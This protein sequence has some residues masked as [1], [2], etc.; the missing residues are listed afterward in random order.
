MSQE[1]TAKRAASNRPAGAHPGEG[2]RRRRGAPGKIKTRHGVD[3]TLLVVLLLLMVIG[4]IMIYSSSGYTSLTMEKS[5]SSYSFLK[6]QLLAEFLGAFATLLIC[7]F[8]FDVVRIF[9]KKGGRILLLIVATFL[10]LLLKTNYGVNVNG[11]TRWVNLFGVVQ[12]QPA[13]FVKIALIFFMAGVI[14]EHPLVMQKPK[15]KR[16]LTVVVVILVNVM[17]VY[18]IS[19]NLS[20]AIIVGAIGF[21]MMFFVIRSWWIYVTLGGA[22]GA[23]VVMV[24][25][26]VNKMAAENRV[27]EMAYQLK[28]VLV[29]QHP[30]SYLKSG[31]Y[32]TVQAL[33]AI[34]SG[35][36]AG[37][38][39][40]NGV[41]K[42][43]VIPEVYNDMIFSEVCEEMG[44]I[45]A[46]LILFLFAILLFRVLYIANNSGT[47]FERMFCLGVFVH[48]AL[49]VILNI[50][51]VTNTMPNTGVSLPFFSYGGTSAAFLT[52]EMGI[53]LA[54]SR[55]IEVKE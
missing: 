38:G 10:M 23:V 22:L 33:Y 7:V 37:K 3:I 54:I 8:P 19:S 11:A 53:V 24:Q 13:E 18:K 46:M 12:F 29:W 52:V 27:D 28:R 30:E 1:Q 47:L 21:G 41:Q 32:Q 6:K 35:G 16:F 44:L 51:V 20:S 5:T 25:K 34:G 9:G 17:L 4:L 36:F 55:R 14:D 49:Q 50:M 26:Y 15:S 48:I 45:G 42:I 2:K 43:G 31:G 40:G 39:L